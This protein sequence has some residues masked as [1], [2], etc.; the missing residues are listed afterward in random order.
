MASTVRT[1]CHPTLYLYQGLGLHVGLSASYSFLD[2][3]SLYKASGFPPIR[4]P[5]SYWKLEFHIATSCPLDVFSC[6]KAWPL[7][8]P[9]RL[10]VRYMR[11]KLIYSTPIKTRISFTYPRTLDHVVR[12]SAVPHVP[13]DHRHRGLVISQHV[14]KIFGPFVRFSF[15]LLDVPDLDSNFFSRGVPPSRCHHHL[16]TTA[17]CKIVP[18]RLTAGSG[19]ISSTRQRNRL[20]S[21]GCLGVTTK[22][23]FNTGDKAG[24]DY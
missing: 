6:V 14:D 12:S 21:R 20:P 17:W 19:K 1:G 3:I 8:F 22:F 10:N 16:P 13:L 9:G 18:L 5:P 2:W 23:Y 4:C 7:S 11:S 24:R 15:T